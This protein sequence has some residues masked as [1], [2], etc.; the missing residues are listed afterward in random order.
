MKF[1][2]VPVLL[3]MASIFVGS[4]VTSGSAQGAE[5]VQSDSW[6]F[7]ANIYGWLVDAPATI[8]V[9]GE[10]VVDVPEDLGTIL[11]DAEALAMVEFEA[12]KGRLWLF[13]DLIYY[14]GEED[15]KFTGPVLGTSRKFTLEEEVLFF[16]Y[17]TGYEFGPWDVGNNNLSTLT[18]TPWVGAVYFRDDWSVKVSPK[19][20][21]GGGRA[22]ATFWF[23]TPMV[24][25]V[26]RSKLAKDW[27]L[28][29]DYGYGGWGV[30]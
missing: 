30:G 4:A 6:K 27:Y 24:G 9:D 22:S 7:R 12:R 3:L 29:L 20:E 13:T 14:K 16:K 15:D 23:N 19:N 28:E 25:A 2:G 5:S 18:V 10:E 1:A 11:D 26:S 8:S 17:G 21:P